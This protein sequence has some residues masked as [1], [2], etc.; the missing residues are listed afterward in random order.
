MS[1]ISILHDE[2]VDC[3]SVMTEMEIEDFLRLVTDVYK[4]RGGIE[5]QR[6]PL[7]TKTGISI[8]SR[9]VSDLVDGAVIPPIVIG[10]QATN[11]LLEAITTPAKDDSLIQQIVAVE[12]ASLSII[13]GMQRTTA[14]LEAVG[15]M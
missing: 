10:V 13:D 11:I 12:A 5:G 14:L 4:E 6:A 7:K 1:A 8:R 3:Y 15:Q 2:R 9:L